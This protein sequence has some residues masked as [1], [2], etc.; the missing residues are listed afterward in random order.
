MHLKMEFDSRIGPTFAKRSQAP[1]PAQ[2][3]GLSLPQFQLIQTPTPTTIQQGKFISC[4]I[5]FFHQIFD[6][7]EIRWQKNAQ[8]PHFTAKTILSQTLE[9]KSKQN[10][11]F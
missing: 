7:L 6:Q 4:Y 10:M 1:A 8:K 9:L 3:A 11:R 2:L 5:I